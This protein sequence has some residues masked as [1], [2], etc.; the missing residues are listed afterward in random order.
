MSETVVVNKLALARL[1]ASIDAYDRQPHL[2]REQIALRSFEDSPIRQL[3][4]DLNNVESDVV[5][6]G[7]IRMVWLNID[8]GEF[9]NSWQPFELRT[10]GPLSVRQLIMD[11]RAADIQRNRPAWK[12]IRYSC[13]TDDAFEFS[14]RMRIP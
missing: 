1:L 12:L 6:K 3:K 14:S 5:E 7:T 13:L 2:L 11:A 4:Q 8:T 10:E 9:S